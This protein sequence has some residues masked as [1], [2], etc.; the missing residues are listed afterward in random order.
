MQNDAVYIV[1]NETIRPNYEPRLQ[2]PL[3][4]GVKWYAVRKA[5]IRPY[6]VRK[7]KIKKFAIHR[8]VTLT[9]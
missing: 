7:A 5:K 6:A 1:A 4:L 8:G 9:Y 3:V 2:T